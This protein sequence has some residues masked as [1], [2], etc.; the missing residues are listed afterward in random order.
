MCMRDC[1]PLPSTAD[2]RGGLLRLVSLL[3]SLALGLAPG[4]S[5][6]VGPET[7]P[8]SE[9][10]RI[11]I[12]GSDTML[13]LTRRWAEEY[14][15]EHPRVAVYVWGGGTGRGLDDLIHQ[16][17]D[18]SAASRPP[19]PDEVHQLA[20]RF[21]SVGLSYAVAKEAL[22]VYVN[23][24]NPV[25]NLSTEQL[26]QIFSGQ[27]DNWRAVGGEDAPIRVFRRSSASG[28]YLYLKEHV[29]NGAEYS[30]D[31]RIVQDTPEMVERVAHDVHA[32]GYGGVAYGPDLHIRVNGVVPS[33]ETIRNGAYPITRYLYLISIASPRGDARR[34]VDWVQGHRGQEIAR[35]MGFVSLW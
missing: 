27:I 33:E 9:S 23:P 14:M 4:C 21:G 8:V 24:G 19:Q 26:R 7:L 34:F 29:L 17:V 22:S 3:F 11:R 31:A 16:R 5:A 32:I 35:G 1:N 12:S 10:G 18:L 28:T 25:R 30:S 20:E 15:R 6:R 13:I 2:R